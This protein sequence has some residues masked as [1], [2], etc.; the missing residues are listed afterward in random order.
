MT[1]LQAERLRFENMAVY[2]R[3]CPVTI[4]RSDSANPTPPMGTSKAM[5]LLAEKWDLASR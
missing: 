3:N 2:T 5:L 4:A 1:Y